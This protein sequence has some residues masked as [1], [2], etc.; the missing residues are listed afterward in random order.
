M[1]R[2]P[3][4]RVLVVGVGS[5]GERHLRFFGRTGRADVGLV[6]VNAAVRDTVAARYGVTRS[7][8]ELEAALA[9]GFEAAV[10]ATPAHLH[11]PVATRLA[12]AGLDLLIEKPLS[13]G[14]DG[15][16]SLRRSVAERGGIAAVAYNYRAMAPLAALRDA[17]VS[18]R[19][20]R[21]LEI[22]ACCGQHFPF[23]RPAYREIYYRDR[24]TGGGAV[25]DALTHVLNAAEWTVGPAQRLVADA[26]HL[27]LEGVDV[28][29]TVHVLARHAGVLASYSLNQHQAPSE[30]TLTVVCERGTARFEAHENRWRWAVEPGAPWQ[31]E[32]F[33]AVERDDAYLRQAELFLDARERKGTVACTL[34]EG[35]QTLRVNL[36]IL[37]SLDTGGWVEI[38]GVK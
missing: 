36:A 30:V 28:E 3:L 1:S 26:A 24:A 37:A 16:E 14:L 13:T 32:P 5:I 12:E 7:F 19:F 20:G 15:I 18:G 33:A 4:H 17:V 6:E 22:V 23:Y 35:L 11:V 38:G 29:D 25:Q 21:A 9:A 27:A 8:A 2:S 10:V 34:E 31:D